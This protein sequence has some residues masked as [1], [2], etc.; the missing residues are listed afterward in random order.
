MNEKRIL[1]ETE[2]AA[3]RF[4]HQDF[5]GRPK[6]EAAIMMGITVRRVQQLLASVEEKCPQLS[7]VLPPQQ[8]KVQSLI[9]DQGCSYEQ[10]AVILELSVV[11]VASTVRALRDKNVFLE[12]RKKTVRYE[13]HLDSQVTERF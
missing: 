10:I 13:N 12:K 7:R 6:V 1:T 4:C 11:A 5:D 8:A 2:E 3:Y 9:N